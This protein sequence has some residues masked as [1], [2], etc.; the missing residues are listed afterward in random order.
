MVLFRRLKPKGEYVFYRRATKL[1]RC[2]ECHQFIEPGEKFVEDHIPYVKARKSGEG[3]IFWHT[4]FVC[5]DCWK[6]PLPV[7]WALEP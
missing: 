6:G 5:L 7:R 2:D 4:H 1:K 3:F